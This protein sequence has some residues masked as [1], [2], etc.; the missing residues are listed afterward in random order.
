MTV[1]LD[2][3]LFKGASS[4]LS[5]FDENFKLGFFRGLNKTATLLTGETELIPGYQTQINAFRPLVSGG[6]VTGKVGKRN[7]QSDAVTFSSS[8]TQSSSGRFTKRANARFHQFELTI[9][10]DE[11]T[12]AIGVEIGPGDFNRSGTRG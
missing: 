9:T 4:Q 1:S 7:R 5:A 11:W 10:G 8:L 12:D 2:S 6:T 3:D